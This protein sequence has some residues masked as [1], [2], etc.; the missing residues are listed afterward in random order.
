MQNEL[1]KRL[2]PDFL[3]LLPSGVD[4][5]YAAIPQ[6]DGLSEPLKDQVK[7]AFADSLSMV[8]KV[9]AAV[10]GVGLLV[11]LPMKELHMHVVTDENWGMEKKETEK[12]VEVVTPSEK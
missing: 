1:L 8:W 6:I 7:V 5:A 2:P 10:A 3:A 11:T 9:M 4:I 12:D